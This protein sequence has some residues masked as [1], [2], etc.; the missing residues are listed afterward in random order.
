MNLKTIQ[1]QCSR[2]SALYFP[3][4]YG[5]PSSQFDYIAL[6]LG[7]EVGEIQNIVKK[8]L[9]GSIPFLEMI[10]QV[11]DELPD[12]LIYLCELASNLGI[13]LE[14]AYHKKREFNNGRFIRPS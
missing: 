9:R 7:G 13:D 2:D 4:F 11:E 5:S 14:A 8:H 1:E 3:E 6:A 12:V 10:M